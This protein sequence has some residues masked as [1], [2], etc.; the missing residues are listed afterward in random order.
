MRKILLR[1]N[2]IGITWIKCITKS[3]F[4]VYRMK[5]IT[6]LQ[7]FIAILTNIK[8]FITINSNLMIWIKK[9][10]SNRFNILFVFL[11]ARLRSLGI[12]CTV[13]PKMKLLTIVIERVE[14]RGKRNKEDFGV[15]WYESNDYSE[16]SPENLSISMIFDLSRICTSLRQLYL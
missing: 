11:L 1:I 13:W 3:M 9:L 8:C 15:F 6:A 16:N 10:W 2:I 5:N 7:H 12:C 4:T 14:K